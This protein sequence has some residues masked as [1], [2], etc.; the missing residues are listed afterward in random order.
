MSKPLG[1]LTNFG[2]LDDNQR[3]LVRTALDGANRSAGYGLCFHS[4]FPVGAAI[5]AAN[6]TGETRIFTGCNVEN[7]YFPATICA[8]RNAATTAALFGYTQFLAVAVF[9]RKYPGGSPCGLCRQVLNQFGRSAILLNVVDHDN[10]VRRATIGDLLPGAICEAQDFEHL[11]ESD[12]RQVRKL[13]GLMSRCHV[14]Y[15]KRPRAALFTAKNE[16][17]N[18]RTFPGVSDDNASYGGSA[19]AEAVAMRTAR[20]AGFGNDVSLMITVENPEGTNPIDGE[21]LQI[22]REFGADAPISL[23]GPDRRV[24]RSSLVELLPDSFG[25]ES[26]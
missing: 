8:E 24:I 23:V 4:D 25:P 26:L 1:I 14:P 21:C 16:K 20:T 10:N 3:E 11:G 5:Y 6:A 22:L 9:C 13:V 2:D 19:L 17:G 7:D 12:K 15:S 18:T